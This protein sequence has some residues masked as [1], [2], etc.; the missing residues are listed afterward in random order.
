LAK[1]EFIK[2]GTT[3]YQ[4]L[5][6]RLKEK[7]FDFD[8]IL[9]EIS[10][11]TFLLGGKPGV[12]W[13]V[14]FDWLI[15]PSNYPKI[16]EGNYRDQKTFQVGENREEDDHPPGYWEKVRELKEK[17]LAGEALMTELQ[18]IYPGYF[19]GGHEEAK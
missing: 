6:A 11:S 15:C 9:N 17:G 16:L 7:H 18:K 12:D 1:V 3:R 14:T 8:S 13:R 19:G 4:K 5:K 10:N 2:P